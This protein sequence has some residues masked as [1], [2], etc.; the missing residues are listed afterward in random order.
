[1]PAVVAC[2]KCGTPIEPHYLNLDHSVGCATCGSELRALVF[3]ALYREFAATPAEQ[4]S[5]LTE[6]SCFYHPENR[7]VAACGLCGRF[8]CGICRIEI[9]GEIVC[10][11]CVDS[12]IRTRKL[13]R[14]ES[15]R[16]MYDTIALLLATVPILLVWPTILTA[17]TAIYV[18]IRYWRAPS[19]LVRRSK[20]RFILAIVI[21]LAQIVIWA[22]I[23]VLLLARWRQ[24]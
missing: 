6:A 1:M 17:P 21:A 7:A 9:S 10:P 19:S 4:V 8:V 23:A 14:F 22:M 2:S 3:P 16:T 18:A 24:P 13:T 12:G 20:L 11:A 15:R 5:E